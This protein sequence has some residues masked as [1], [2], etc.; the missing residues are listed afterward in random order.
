MSSLLTDPFFA[1]VYG[2]GLSQVPLFVLFLGFTFLY[3]FFP[4]TNVQLRAAALGAVVA[5]VLFSVA[6][7]IYVD[8]QIGAAT[9][10]AVF[11]ALAAIPLILAWLYVCW[12]VVLLGAEVAFA[13]QN[14][15]NAR[16]EMNAGDVTPAKREAIAIEVAV[17]IAEHFLE[18]R[19]PPSSA[20]LADHLDEPIRLVRRLVGE[21]EEAD[22]VRAVTTDDGNERAWVPARPADEL[23]IGDVLRAVRGESADD[24][25][26][27]DD[28]VADMLARLKRATHEVADRA[29]LESLAQGTVDDSPGGAA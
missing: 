5:A 4:N 3:W 20:A 26:S 28:P 10:Q 9:Y 13:M 2:L 15:P 18:G 8:F 21:L 16:R 24:A 6:R 17:G 29:S 22:L 19:E 25:P 14:L 12:A 23:T 7:A 27:S 1:R 11:G